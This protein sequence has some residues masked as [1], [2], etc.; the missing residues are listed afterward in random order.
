MHKPTLVQQ[1]QPKKQSNNGVSGLRPI[2]P[3]EGFS[4]GNEYSNTFNVLP[5]QTSRYTGSPFVNKLG[6]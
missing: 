4:F 5:A 2:K 1:P 6:S 3:L